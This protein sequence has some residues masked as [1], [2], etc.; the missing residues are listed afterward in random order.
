MIEN[1]FYSR[2]M[3]GEFE[4]FELGNLLL[5]S[6]QTLRG[7]KLAYRTIGT[8]NAEKTNAILVTTWFSGTGRVMQEV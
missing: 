1:P 7:A 3:Q 8:L 4:L 6:G 2:E 5:E